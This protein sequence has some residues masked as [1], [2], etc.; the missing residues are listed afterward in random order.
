MNILKMFGFVP[1]RNFFVWITTSKGE[2]VHSNFIIAK[3][4][5][6]A[7]KKYFGANSKM[8]EIYGEVKGEMIDIEK[9][10]M[11]KIDNKIKDFIQINN[12]NIVTIY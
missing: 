9:C 12:K 4:P 1:K 11:S 6:L 5:E 7:I 3:S 10:D 8:F 2:I